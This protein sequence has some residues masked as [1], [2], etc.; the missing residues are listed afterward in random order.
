MMAEITSEWC[1]CGFQLSSIIAILSVLTHLTAINRAIEVKQSHSLHSIS[2][3]MGLWV[4]KTGL[5]L[6]STFRM[7]FVNIILFTTVFPGRLNS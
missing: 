3:S 4:E 2:M 5:C 6:S 1:F 7:R